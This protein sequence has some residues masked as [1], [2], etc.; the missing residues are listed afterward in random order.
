MP[1][2]V[3]QVIAR[4][5]AGLEGS[6]RI[7]LDV[8]AVA[9]QDA[10]LDLLKGLHS[11]AADELDELLQHAFDR[12]LLLLQTDGR[13][14]RFS[15]A[16]VRQAV[17]E[18]I[19]PLRRRT[20]HRQV[21][22]RLAGRS[23]PDA[24]RVAHHFYRATDERALDWLTQAAEAAQAVF[25]PEAV[26]L[27]CRQAIDLSNQL[28]VELP[29]QLYR[30][31]GLALETVGD[32]DGALASH[33]TALS[34]ARL[35]DVRRSEWQALLDL[36]ALWASRD[37]GR[38]GDYCRQAVD[39]ARALDDLAA[40]G[41]SLNR[42]GNWHINGAFSL[43]GLACHEEALEVF[44]SIG[45]RQGVA[46]TFDLIAST[47]YMI[48]DSVAAIETYENAIPLLR[49]VEDLRTLSSALASAA[50]C[51]SGYIGLR[52]IW[53][54]EF[55]ESI[56]ADPAAALT[57]S[58]ELARSTG[59]SS[60]ECF[61]LGI[62]G[63]HDGI[64]GEIRSGFST[65]HQSQSLAE[66]AEHRLWFS[67]GCLH[68]GL[69]YSGLGLNSRSLQQISA[70]ADLH[71]MMG[72]DHQVIQTAGHLAV[73]HV[74][75]G[76]LQEAALLIE[77]RDFEAVPEGV[78]AHRICTYAASELALAKGDHAAALRLIDR[79]LESLRPGPG[80]PPPEAVHLKGRI[81]LALGRYE[82]AEERLT[83][84]LDI[85]EE[86][87]LRLILWRIHASL[88][89]LYIN[90]GRLVDARRSEKA[91]LEVIDALAGQIDDPDLRDEFL[92]VARAEA[93]P[94]LPFS[95]RGASPKVEGGLTPRELEVL[96][97]VARGLTNEEASE[98]LF[99]SPRTVDQ[100]LRSIYGKL[101][102]TNRTA[103]SR[104]ATEK[105]LL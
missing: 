80:H 84:A 42:L 61:A 98:Q 91:A 1:S 40:L 70:A 35:E 10:T 74:R 6:G 39:L 3:K 58:L 49:E 105:N 89:R 30:L 46:S 97:L 31:Q 2:L 54:P 48:G 63:M 92:T 43:D 24:A 22:E 12:H 76:R 67:A 93:A 60:G 99:I 45:D 20:L 85:A 53:I 57:E 11:G 9:G 19:P 65:L 44:E 5:M 50:A 13:G 94:D 78:A 21:G 95:A 14:V 8:A 51:R 55:P 56:G 66:E 102:V 72:S 23:R 68:L 64:R 103:A 86:L 75:E 33:E 88:R 4:R 59:W 38:T 15:H 41:H 32:F 101:G 69:L 47:H 77:G 71:A 27:L 87:N 34:R 90:E 16:L 79:L 52:N 82:D 73:A 29:L 25:A 36:G 28:E 96:R 81:L 104:I 83:H 18:A 62:L 26:V 37:F 7:I 100:H 17:Y